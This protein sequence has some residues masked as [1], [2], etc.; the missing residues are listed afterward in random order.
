MSW[1]EKGTVVATNSNLV[2]RAK[3]GRILHFPHDDGYK[4]GDKVTL[5]FSN[6]GKASILESEHLHTS[7][8]PEAPPIPEDVNYSLLDSVE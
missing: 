6:K 5:I 8:P 3:F 1:Q 4:D 7:T 2:I